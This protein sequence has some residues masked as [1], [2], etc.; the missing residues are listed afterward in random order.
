ME[1]PTL[2]VIVPVYN[3]RNTIHSIVDRLRAIPLPMQIIAVNDCSKDGSREILDSLRRAGSIDVV[4]H[5]EVNRGKGA[6]LRTGIAHA[7]GDV[8]VVQ[9]ADLEYHEDHRQLDGAAPRS[10]RPGRDSSAH[11]AD[12]EGHR[13]RHQ[14]HGR[15][16]A[17]PDG[18]LGPDRTPALLVGARVGDE[19]RQTCSGDR[20]QRQDGVHQSQHH[21]REGVESRHGWLRRG[22]LAGLL[23]GH[24]PTIA[25]DILPRDRHA[26]KNSCKQPV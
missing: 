22:I 17:H 12:D 20:D 8:I 3:E 24:P 16:D 1:L 11:A 18:D 15:P 14:H 23:G 10:G 19:D 6:A 21:R 5:H 4:A 7:T 25:P 9:D 26:V 2:S 13:H